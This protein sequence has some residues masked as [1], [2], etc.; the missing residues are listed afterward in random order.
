VKRTFQ[1]NNRRRKKKHGFRSRMKTA[2][3]RAVLARRRRKGRK[4]LAV[5]SQRRLASAGVQA[6]ECAAGKISCVAIAVVVGGTVSVQRSIS[7]AT[8]RRARGSAPLLAGR[9]VSPWSDTVW[10]GGS[11][12]SYGVTPSEHC[13]RRWM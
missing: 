6:T 3:G 4:R 10:S 2:Q 13:C 8:S 12:R 11:G 1:P 5:W 7:I 9:L